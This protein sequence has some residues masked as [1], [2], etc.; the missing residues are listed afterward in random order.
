MTIEEMRTIDSVK[1]WKELEDAK[2]RIKHLESA[3]RKTID[4]NRHLADGDNC[5]LIDLKKALA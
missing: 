1:T 4:N 3:I 2:E 5:T